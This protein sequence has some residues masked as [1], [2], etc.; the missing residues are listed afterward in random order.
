MQASK[1]RSYL[2]P[3][4]CFCENLGDFPLI[5]G[6]RKMVIVYGVT[7]RQFNKMV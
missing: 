1:L 7:F 2:I 4:S 6:K 3:H 5:K